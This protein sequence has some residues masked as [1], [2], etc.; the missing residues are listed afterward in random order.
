MGKKS[1]K[2]DENR[3]IEEIKSSLLR[4][5]KFRNCFFFSKLSKFTKLHRKIDNF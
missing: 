5:V 3:K 1:D 4:N 2:I